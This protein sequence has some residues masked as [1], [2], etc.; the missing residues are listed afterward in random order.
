MTTPQDNKPQEYFIPISIGEGS[1]EDENPR[2][3][4]GSQSA[5]SAQSQS[6]GSRSSCWAPLD[7]AIE[8]QEDRSS[9]P[10]NIYTETTL[11]VEPKTEHEKTMQD[12]LVSGSLGLMKLAGG[13]TLSTTGKLIMPPLKITKEIIIPALWE[14]TKDRVSFYTPQ[15]L[16]DWFQ[17]VFASLYNCVNVLK[18]TP[19]GKIFRSKIEVVGSD[20]VD[21]LTSDASRQCIA[22]GMGTLVKLSEALQ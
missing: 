14:A 7:T 13:I 12:R 22:D 1:D 4:Q 17:I 20:I 5:R 2:D 16:K 8:E 21:C 6:E 3:V 15:R 11:P 10:T 19:K 9:T 18:N